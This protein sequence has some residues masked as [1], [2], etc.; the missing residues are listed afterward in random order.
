VL[1][2]SRLHAPRTVPICSISTRSREFSYYRLS[3]SM[4]RRGQGSRRVF[5]FLYTG[6]FRR[7]PLF[8]TLVVEYAKAAPDDILMQLTVHN[9][10]A[11]G[12]PPLPLAA[13]L[14]HQYLDVALPTTKTPISK[15]KMASSSS[16]AAPPVSEYRWHV[17]SV[18]ELISARRT[19]AV[20]FGFG[21]RYRSPLQQTLFTTILM[22]GHKARSIRTAKGTK[23]FRALRT[24]GASSEAKTIRFAPEPS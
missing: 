9:R 6:H 16:P 3:I 17:R 5:E 4:R 12:R 7:R 19:N 22:G 18:K 23:A 13:A 8:S 21:N 20:G 24:Q 1:L 11:R 10:R 14:V 15:A 2:L